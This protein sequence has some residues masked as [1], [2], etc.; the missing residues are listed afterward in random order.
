M[1][2]DNSYNNLIVLCPN[3]HDLAHRGGLTLG[4]KPEQ[5]RTIKGK[6]ELQVEVANAQRVARCI[7][8]K[9][10]AIDY[11]NVMRIEE[12]CV[13]LFG[14][15]PPTS[16]SA[17]L[18]RIGI[19]GEGLRFD[20]KFV[21]TQLSSGRY[22]FDYTNCSE[23]EHYRQLL[24]E[25]AKV[26]DF[27]DLSE[28]AETGYSALRNLEGRYAFFIGGVYS[29]QPAMPIN[30][31]TPPIVMHYTTRKGADRV[32]HG[33]QLSHVHVLYWAYGTKEPLYHLRLG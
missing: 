16:I 18:R 9:D 29:K 26:T 1:G 19:L 28:A 22:L 24:R 17:Y 14:A 15:V 21:R 3:D 6:W 23:T 8:A 25:V 27:E 32:G 30:V 13:R 5:L 31:N 20:Q 7:I 10:D 12:L 2:Q 33:P 4:L 11:V